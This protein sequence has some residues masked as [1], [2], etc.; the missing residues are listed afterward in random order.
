[1]RIVVFGANGPT[2]RLL[3]TQALA[4]GHEVSAVTRHPEQMP[5]P[6]RVT[7]VRADVTDAEAVVEGTIHGMFTDLAACLLAQLTDDRYVRR[8]AGV[9]T[10]TGTPG[11]VRQIW[12]EGIK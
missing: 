10:T 9:V 7:V 1:M 4:A 5:S 8:T 12:R 2:G 6:R 11:L 3:V